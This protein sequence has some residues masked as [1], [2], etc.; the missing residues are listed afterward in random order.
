MGTE[1]SRAAVQRQHKTKIRLAAGF[2]VLGI[3]ILVAL[4]WMPWQTFPDLRLWIPFSLAFIYFEWNS[5]EVNDRL[6]ASP[7]IMVLLTATV[8]FGPD[9]AVIGAATMAALAMVTPMD[10]LER[11]WFQPIVNFGQLVASAAIASAVLALVVG[12]GLP[13]GSSSL[14]AGL[15]RIALGSALGSVAYGTANYRMVLFIVSRVYGR[16]EVRPWSHIGA[17]LLPM[18]GM[19]FLG[20][21]LGATYLIIGTAALPLI[22]VVFFAGYLAF[23]SYARLREAQE[24]TIRGF[25]K[26][27]E[28]K[29]LYT[30]GH[31]ERVARFAEM[32]GKQMGY[33]GTQLERVRWAALIH[34]VGKLAVPRELIRKRARLTEEE[35]EVMQ[36]HVHFVEDLLD[37][38]EFLKPM[39]EIASNHHAHYDGNG[40]H[41]IGHEHGDTPSKEA[42]ILAVADTFDAITST[43]SYRVALTQPYAYA[44]LR[45]H[46][47]SQFDP[48]VV[49]AFI[50]GMENSGHSYGSAVELT[51]LEARKIAEEGLEEIRKA[52]Q[53]H[54]RDFPLA[55]MSEGAADA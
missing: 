16:F 42:C 33:D 20:G 53:I 36:H 17:I 54:G 45:R 28:A 8:I 29:D 46:A 9:G 7:S 48:E 21:L 13:S 22:A 18:T 52:D 5:V 34:D 3:A 51:D 40:Y 4:I 12:V 50:S 19:G 25:I 23:E 55:P 47:G 31:T 24:S 1:M 10:V 49:E 15:W 39:I 2:G 44:E 32:I 11:R 38:V 26:A 27:L 43:R 37:D 30:R 6:F 14:D 35:Y 41:G